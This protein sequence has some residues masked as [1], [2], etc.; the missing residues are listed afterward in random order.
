[1]RS[2]LVGISLSVAPGEAVY[3]P[4]KQAGLENP[5]TIDEVMPLLKPIL[6]DESIPKVGQNM[7]FDWHIL[8]RYGA[9][10]KG[11]ADDTMLA[12]YIFDP[13]GNRH[14]MDALAELYLGFKTTPFESIA[15]KGKSQK[16]FDEID[17]ETAS[18]YAAEDADI[19]LQ[20]QKIVLC[21]V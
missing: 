9:E 19:T 18:F 7:K 20:L 17:I 5:L 10:I 4:F 12:S 21:L 6:E 14:N 16:T 8:K 2:N 11:I 1:M 15:G 13:T 3:I